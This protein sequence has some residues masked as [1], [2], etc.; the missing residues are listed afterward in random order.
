MSDP[1]SK[2]LISII[3]ESSIEDG[4][5]ALLREMKVEGH[6]VWEVRGHGARGARPG[7]FDMDR[8]LKFEVLCSEATAEKIMSEVDRRFFKDYGVVLYATTV[9]VRRAEK[10]S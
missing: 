8:N 7:D 4:L 5:L 6:T 9:R 10:F 3:A 1:H 2:V